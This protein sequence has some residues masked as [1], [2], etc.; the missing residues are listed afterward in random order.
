[1]YRGAG[2]WIARRSLCGTS[3]ASSTGSPITFM[4][5]P[6]V[7]SPTGMAIGWPV[8]VTPAAHQALAR[9]HRDG[10]TVDSPRCWATRAP[11]VALVLGLE[12]V[13]NRGAAAF[14]LHVDTA[15]DDL[16]DMSDRIGHGRSLLARENVDCRVTR[17]PRTGDDLDQLLGDHRLA[18][19]VVGQRLLA[20]I[21]PALRW[22][23]PSR[24]SAPRRTRRHFPGARGGSAPRML[25]GRAGEDLVLLGSYSYAA[26][27]PPPSPRIRWDE[28]LRGSNLRHHRLEA[29]EDSVQTS[30]APSSLEPHDL[31]A[32]AFG[33]LEAERAHRA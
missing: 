29:R 5:R 2:W 19:A 11:G 21:S 4:M 22:H 10:R 12:R 6:S 7:P 3:P 23:C 32:D 25:R 20:I 31:V 18:R 8:S 9:I 14:E 27:L 30:N 26:S 17:R 24:S 28:L 16:G 13:E 33:M 15:A 1:V